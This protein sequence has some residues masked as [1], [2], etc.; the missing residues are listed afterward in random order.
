MID[1]LF[2]LKGRLEN[3]VPIISIA[4][5]LK[6]SGLVISILCENA[7]SKLA[8]ELETQGIGILSMNLTERNV[9]G[10]RSVLWKLF[11]WCR[12]RL[13]ATRRIRR[14][15]FYTLYIGTAD[16]AIAL[17]GFFEKQFDYVLHLRELYDQYPVYMFLLKNIACNAK[18]V[19]VPEIN[20]AHIYRVHFRLGQTPVVI[21]NKPFYHP[22]EKR[23][24]L[25]F[26]Q[27]SVRLRI[28]SK[29]NIVYQGLLHEERDL[30]SLVKGVL[31]FDNCNLILMGRDYGMLKKY[32][33]I[34]SNIIHIPFVTPPQHLNI[35]SW[36]TVGIISYDLDSLNTVYCAP[37]K[38][39]EFAGFGVPILGNINPGIVNY[40]KWFNAGEIVD[41]KNVDEI[42]SGLTVMFNNIEDYENSAI[43]LYESFNNFSI[44]DLLH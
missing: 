18:K 25:A 33:E 13:Q 15:Q 29:V 3:A 28:E 5:S 40:V 14:L 4:Q 38:I 27:D 19:V 17:K 34:N 30:T 16:T 43:E 31:G 39:W 41:F 32:L 10:F 24:D 8:K 21:P 1:F 35:T 44:R 20:R 2:V 36:A 9:K 26:L 42:V 37:N 22:R 6:S 7:N 23:L 11:T 12:F